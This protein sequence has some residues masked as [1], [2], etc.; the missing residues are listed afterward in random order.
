M[1][2]KSPRAVRFCDQ[3]DGFRQ[4]LSDPHWLAKVMLGGFL[5]INPFLV[6]LAP[7][8]FSGAAPEWVK[9]SLP[10]DSRL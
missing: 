10:V 1:V 6:A 2:P 5:L 8:Y 3:K 4:I 9:A 7:S